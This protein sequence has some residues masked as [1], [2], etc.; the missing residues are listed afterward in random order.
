[1]VQHGREQTKGVELFSSNTPQE[2]IEKTEA[3]SSQRRIQQKD[4]SQ[5]AGARAEL[6]GH[7]E[8]R[9]PMRVVKP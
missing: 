8:E 9:F 6:A 7:K 1:M 2:A 5:Q 4:R 3:D